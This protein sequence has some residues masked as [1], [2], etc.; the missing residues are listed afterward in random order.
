MYIEFIYIYDHVLNGLY[1]N[2]IDTYF[3]CDF[4]ILTSTKIL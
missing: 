1:S 3:D 2:Y 4:H